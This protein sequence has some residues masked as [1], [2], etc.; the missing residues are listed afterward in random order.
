[1]ADLEA[2]VD[3]QSWMS[4]LINEKSAR[5]FTLERTLPA[6]HD[7]I[8]ATGYM[9]DLETPTDEASILQRW[10]GGQ[11]RIN[12]KGVG[13]GRG[14]KKV[15]DSFVFELAGPPR[16]FPGPDKAPVLFPSAKSAASPTDDR[17]DDDDDED[18]FD[19]RDRHPREATR[20]RFE[21][22]PPPGERV[23]RGD[24]RA[25][26][27][28]RGDR[29]GHDLRFDQQ[30]LPYRTP[31]LPP[32]FDMPPPP[33][34]DRSPAALVRE[35]MLQREAASA[36]NGAMR[37]LKEASE[38]AQ[39]ALSK[40]LEALAQDNMVLRDSLLARDDRANKPYEEGM[41][42][43][44]ARME[45]Q[46]Q[47]FAV[48]TAALRTSYEQQLTSLRA[49]YDQQLA[50]LRLNHEQQVAMLGQR[51]EGERRSLLDQ[52]ESEVKTLQRQVETTREDMSQRLRDAETQARTR[53]EEAVRMLTASFDTRIA[54]LT[55]ERDAAQR[56]ADE[57]FQR[58]TQ[59]VTT[60]VGEERRYNE[61]STNLLKTML[62]GREQATRQSLE[63]EVSRLRDELATAR[64]E[65][66]EARKNAEPQVALSKAAT[67]AEQMRNLGMVGPVNA[68]KS[69]EPPVPDD[70]M[71][72]IA[73]YAPKLMGAVE[74]VLRRADD[75]RQG[76]IRLREHQ[77]SAQ[78]QAHQIAA[79]TRLAL[80]GQASG[81]LPAQL[82]APPAPT[83]NAPTTAPSREVHQDVAPLHDL[84]TQL[85]QA[86]SNSLEPGAVAELVRMQQGN[87]TA[88]TRQMLDALLE[89]PSAEVAGELSTAAES[90]GMATLSTPR[91]TRWLQSLHES[92]QQGAE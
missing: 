34:T 8:P 15:L 59:E 50:G 25:S 41:Q 72:K 67:M 20:D 22:R 57:M 35:R 54:L 36:D 90:L 13:S 49:S 58:T 29:F 52:R 17:A 48:Q 6:Y 77:I 7:A 5:W 92:L 24:R 37:I 47:D 31:G 61:S 28:E 38:G 44:K 69:E 70:I 89:R 46:R 71:G 87:M 56:R 9:E 4:K 2:P 51:H 84:L 39:V 30:R 23:E 85:E 80:A 42:A 16:A 26:L 74:P 3:V 32:D 27:G 18:D 76:A 43:L 82:P 12:A 60:R 53:V 91:G 1:M 19:P 88:E 55:S 75:A 68:E 40:Q 73:A 63:G 10:G 86:M 66:V 45:E 62:E 83:G 11:Y 33:L 78:L 14:Q 81:V 65:L 79:Q 21:R 64:A